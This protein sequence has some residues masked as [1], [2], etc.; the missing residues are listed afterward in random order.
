MA[1]VR[2]QSPLKAHLRPTFS[3]HLAKLLV[4]MAL[5]G[6]GVAWLMKSLVDDH[7]TSG[8]LVRAAGCAWDIPVEIHVF[9]SR[10]RLTPAA[11]IFW[12]RLTSGSPLDV[13]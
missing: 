6:R 3:S 13:D 1:A 4:A 2:G 7:L 11:E 5:E 10:S 8:Q 12:N 9:R